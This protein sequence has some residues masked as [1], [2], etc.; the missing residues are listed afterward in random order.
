MEKQIIKEIDKYIIPEDFKNWALGVL[1]G[2]NDKEIEM[3]QKSYKLLEVKYSDL[4]K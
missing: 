3:R 2:Y 1:R 4:Q